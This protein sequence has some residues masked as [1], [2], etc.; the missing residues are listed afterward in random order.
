MID[1]L[2]FTLHV[3]AAAAVFTKR[4]QEEGTGE[5]MLAIAFMALIFFVGWGMAS[6]A[7]KLILPPRGTG[8]VLQPRQRRTRPPDH[9]GGLLLLLL[10]PVRHEESS[11]RIVAGLVR[12]IRRATSRM[13]TPDDRAI[14]TSANRLRCTKGLTGQRRRTSRGKCFRPGATAA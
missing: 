8:E 13:S 12:P 10:L 3:L 1:L 2:V 7:V 9:R 11:R 6:F 14:A 5:A 4:W